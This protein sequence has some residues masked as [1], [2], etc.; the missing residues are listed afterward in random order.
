M[1][2]RNWLTAIVGSVA[3]LLGCKS[4]QVIR[5]TASPLAWQLAK[6]GILSRKRTPTLFCNVTVDGRPV[7]AIM[8]NL[9]KGFATY[10]DKET[11]AFRRVYGYID[12]ELIN[13]IEW[14][15]DD[16]MSVEPIGA[17]TRRSL[18]SEGAGPGDMA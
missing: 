13:P 16:P 1:N 4:A 10:R 14:E 3:W 8:C 17:N 12:I 9:H 18:R 5:G 11:F 6:G 2:R 7:K 15:R